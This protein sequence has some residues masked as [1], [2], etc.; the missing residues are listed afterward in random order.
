MALS[1]DVEHVVRY[2]H[3]GA[4]D[5]VQW[6]VTVDRGELAI[7]GYAPLRAARPALLLGDLGG[8][9]DLAATSFSPSL[10]PGTA[11]WLAAN[12]LLDDDAGEV[13]ALCFRAEPLGGRERPVH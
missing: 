9:A 5:R 1:I 3:D 13:Y 2:L 6:S 10:G 12:A 4:P 7:H 11:P 8:T